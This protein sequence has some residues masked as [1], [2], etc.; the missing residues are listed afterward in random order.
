MRWK[1]ATL[2]EVCSIQTGKTPPTKVVEYFGGEVNWFNPSDIGST[3]LLRKSI[4]SVSQKAVADKK[5][6]L[7][8]TGS[9]LLTC[10][11]EIGR[12]GIL[13]QPSSANQQITALKFNL[14]IDPRFAYYW[15]VV[16]KKRLSDVANNAVV[17]ILNNQALRTIKFEYPSLSVQRQIA[18]TLDKADA[19]RQKDQQ[20]LQKYD[21]LALSIFYEMFGDPVGNER[22]WEIQPL[23]ELSE[24]IQI[25]PFG[26][27]LHA[28][29][30]VS[31]GIP[32]V[33]PSHIRGGLIVPDLDLTVTEDKMRE[34]R[35]YVMRSGDI[36]MGRRGEMGRCA[37]ITSKENGWLCGTGSLFIRPNKKVEPTVL[38]MFLSHPSVRDVLER[39]SLGTTMS[40]LNQKIVSNLQLIAP[41]K[42]VQVM[43]VDAMQSL[44]KQVQVINRSVHQSSQLFQ[45]LLSQNFS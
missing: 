5:A 21:E 39:S 44:S 22:G 27:L 43:F 33:N 34:L 8:P 41:P 24:L 16:N 2:G 10:I 18:D 23:R 12:C 20:L 40:N 42:S 4:R 17:P 15:F 31:G 1:S 29:D 37:V 6:V 9:I 11:G 3:Q 45:N 30:Y 38:G 7:F 28:E 32:L 14:D 19:L 26:S 36:V 25:G 13:S 35:N